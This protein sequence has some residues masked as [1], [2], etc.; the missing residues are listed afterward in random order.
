MTQT[1]SVACKLQVTPELRQQ[2]DATMRAFADGCNQIL[3]VAKAEKV[4][5]KFKLH[6]LCYQ[7]VRAK[8]G[9]RANH[10]VQALARVSHALS[11][12]KQVR[13]FRPTSLQLDIRTFALNMEKEQVGITLLDGR[14]WLP[15]SIGNYQRA[16]LREQ[17]PTFAVLVKRRDGSYYINIAVE[18]TTPPTGKTPKVV[19]VD[20][21]QRDIAHTS[22]GKSWD[23]QHLHDV[24]DRYQRVRSSVQSKRTKGAKRLLRRLSGRERRFQKQVN[25]TISKQLVGEAQSLGAAIAL[26]DLKGIRKAKVR[27]KQRRRQANW[28]FYQLKQFVKYKAAIAGVPVVDVPAPYTSKTCSRCHHIGSRNGKSFK[29][30]HCGLHVDADRN[31]A[32]NIATLGAAFVTSPEDSVMQCTLEGQLPIL[33]VAS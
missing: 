27:K 10:T 26:E 9:L 1:I 8:T 30:G 19:G 17:S 3:K 5:R 32:N 12:R 23:G 15:L 24:R 13:Q 21:G 22:T 7:D 16:L 18:L 33:C 2:I 25:H 11:T 29:C 28:A 4:R 14:V 20:L 6:K 31:A